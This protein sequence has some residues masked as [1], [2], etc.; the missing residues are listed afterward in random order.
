MRWS[1]NAFHSEVILVEM[2][3]SS[4][5]VKKQKVT[6]WIIKHQENW[7]YRDCNTIFLLS[8]TKHINISDLVWI[9]SW[10]LFEIVEIG[11]SNYEKSLSCVCMSHERTIEKEKETIRYNR[12][13]KWIATPVILKKKI[14]NLI[15]CFF[16][17]MVC[18]TLKTLIK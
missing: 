1:Q 7:H 3:I 13:L 9:Y 2:Y 16:F 11:S 8:Y 12:R 5:D 18:I 10:K 6:S 17:L 14:G 4:M 15:M